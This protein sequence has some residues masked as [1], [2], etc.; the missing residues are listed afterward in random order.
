M[1]LGKALIFFLVAFC[2]TFLVPEKRALAAAKTWYVDAS[3]SQSADGTSWLT[4]FKAIQQGIN[5]ASDGDTVTVAEGTYQENVQFKGK[6][7]VL[8][9][10]NP[11]AP[12]VIAKTIIQG[13]QLGPTVT[14]SGTEKPSCW[15]S[16][17]TVWDGK[18]GSGGAIR[19][20]GTLATIGMNIITGGTADNYGG[21]LY[22]CDGLIC[23]N[24]ITVNSSGQGGGGLA[25]CSGLIEFNMI[26]DCWSSEGGALYQCH[27]PIQHNT[28]TNCRASGSG[29]G[30]FACNGNILNNTITDCSTESGGGGL[31]RCGEAG[32]TSV[33]I[34]NNT[35][36]RNRAIR[37]DIDLSGYGGG[38]SG[39][40]G[41]IENNTIAGNWSTIGGGLAY[42]TGLIQNNLIA[43]NYVE[44]GDDLDYGGIGGGLANCGG[45]IRNN[46]IAGNKAYGGSDDMGGYRGGLGGGLARCGGT[47]ENNTITGNRIYHEEGLGGGVADCWGTTRNCIIWANSASQGAQVFESNDVTYCCVQNWYEGGEGNIAL[48]PQLSDP[49]GPDDDP[50]TLEDNEYHLEWDSPC[51]DRGR[52]EEWMWHALDLD[53]NN[54]IW[55]GKDSLRVDM[56]AYEYGSFR[57]TIVGAE[58]TS[59]NQ[60]KL[61]WTS[62]P[63]DTYV[64]TSSGILNRPDWFQEGTV[65]S[66][67]AT[68]SF[69]VNLG[70][71]ARNFYRIE[72]AH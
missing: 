59:S 10:R 32:V 18:A 72:M 19:G 23:L 16:G 49:D 11:L 30:F 51:I 26:S 34:A 33:R 17:F 40:H 56:G 41:V 6:N 5:A 29:G 64:L 67:G 53:G 50:Y 27:G 38:L 43:I 47:I 55:Q 63:G 28:I 15:L 46:V 42:C 66:Q 52:N 12:E 35:I 39:C 13:R 68:T 36:N 31:A 4:A 61:T 8:T 54:R 44:A 69:S 2:L 1:K 20:N 7:I 62:R 57:F 9:G 45:H 65:L 58:R 14:F 24:V 25:F 37:L 3:V 70:T 71:G 48:N 60:L 21:G 22:R